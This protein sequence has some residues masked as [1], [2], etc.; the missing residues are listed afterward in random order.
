M[1][2]RHL[3]DRLVKKRALEGIS[4]PEEVIHYL[5]RFF[6]YMRKFAV[7]PEDPIPGLENTS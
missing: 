6:S 3:Q 7:E 5:N 4:D 1:K 2:F